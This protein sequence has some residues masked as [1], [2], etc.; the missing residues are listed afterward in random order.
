VVSSGA[1]RCSCGAYG[2]CPF[3][4]VSCSGDW[5]VASADDLDHFTSFAGRSA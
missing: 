2:I 4:P 3:I 1:A 5:M